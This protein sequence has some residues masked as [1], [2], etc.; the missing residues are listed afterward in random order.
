M[1]FAEGEEDL[2]TR[3]VSDDCDDRNTARAS[4]SDPT[5]AHASSCTH[6]TLGRARS[7]RST[8]YI[9]TIY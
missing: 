4:D 2:T 3:A 6:I 8:L 5:S 7:L 9:L 1:H